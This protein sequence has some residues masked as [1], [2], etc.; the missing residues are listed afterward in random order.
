[1]KLSTVSIGVL[2]LFLVGGCVDRKAQEIAKNTQEKVQDQ[3]KPVQVVSVTPSSISQTLEITGDTVSTNDSNVGPKTGGKLLAVYVHDGD[4]VNAGQLIAKMDDSVQ[5][6]NLSSALASMATAQAQLSQAVAN[7][8]NAPTRS[9]AAVRQASDALASAEAQY[10]KALA[11]PRTQERAQA[12][13]AV[14]NA[15]SAMDTAKSELDR[16]RSLN[17]QGAVS[18]QRVEQAEQAY[19]AALA[20]Y[21]SALQSQSLVKEG[22]RSEDVEIARQAVSQAREALRSA[23]ATQSLDTTF[24]DQVNAARAGVQAATAQV[25][26]ARTALDDAN[27]RAPF[28]GQVAGKPVQPGTVLGSGTPIAR[29]VSTDSVY[30]EGQVPE[31]AISVIQPGQSVEAQIQA[32]PGQKFSGRVIAVNP[33]GNDAGRLFTVRIAIT[34]TTNVKPGM[35]VRGVATLRTVPNA[36]VVPRSAVLQQGTDSVVFVQDGKKAKRVVVHV[37]LKQGDKVQVEGLQPGEKLIVEGQNGLI[38]GSPVTTNS[39]VKTADSGP[40]KETAKS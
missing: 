27:I 21:N 5:Q 37:L 36:I 7:Q 13:W 14:R 40:T 4:H 33:V 3:T 2:A 32:L 29:I 18:T 10:K 17:S 31:E 34:P 8:R 9:A 28:A 39:G 16:Q 20:G 23:K 26:I 12:D 24:T 1:M 25:S 15:K 11:G 22:T 35:F 38:D 6:S 30:F 19:V